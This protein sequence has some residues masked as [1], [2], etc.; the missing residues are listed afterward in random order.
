MESS[1]EVKIEYLR[2]LFEIGLEE[3]AIPSFRKMREKREKEEILKKLYD[4]WKNCTKCKLH[5]WRTNIVFGQGN[6][7]SKVVFIGE[8]PGE[9]EDKQGLPFVGRAGKLLNLMIKSI[10]LTR[11][12]V[13]ITN[14]IKCRPP[15]NRDPE[16]DEII[17]CS[18]LLQ[19]QLEIINPEI[20]VTLGK[21]AITALS[22]EKLAI[23]KIRGRLMLIN[24]R[25]VLPT[26]HPAFLL[27]NPVKKR[28]A[29]E[30]FKT[31]K[32]LLGI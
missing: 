29:W 22:G 13:F 6:P 8:G 1:I 9:E 26:Y 10:G 5:Q 32:K 19:K 17:A 3:I 14:I 23:T 12:D 21:P 24:G 15:K 7:T 20:I 16:K 4:N 25:K 30:D 2:Y 31:L 18:P 11:D 28:E 27:R